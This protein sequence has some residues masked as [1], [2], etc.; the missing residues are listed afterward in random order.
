MRRAEFAKLKG[1]H[2]GHLRLLQEAHD[3]YSSMEAYGYAKRL[4]EKL[5]KMKK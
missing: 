3:L 2:A 4:K 1:D 5:S